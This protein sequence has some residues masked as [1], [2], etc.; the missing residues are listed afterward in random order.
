MD[1]VSGRSSRRPLLEA[2]VLTKVDGRFWESCS[3]ENSW[4]T[5]SVADFRGVLYF[6]YIIESPGRNYYGTRAVH[7]ST[8]LLVVWGGVD[9]IV[10]VIVIDDSSSHMLLM[11]G[12]HS[13]NHSHSHSRWVI[14]DCPTMPNPRRNYWVLLTIFVSNQWLKK[15]PQPPQAFI[16]HHI[17]WQPSQD[18]GLWLQTMSVADPRSF[19][20][21]SCIM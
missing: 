11:K 3:T 8:K 21:F 18:N 19:L 15:I 1:H 5:M 4:W 20:H 14:H 9:V 17:R 12:S 13:H 6:C 10:I 2:N 16:A 7:D